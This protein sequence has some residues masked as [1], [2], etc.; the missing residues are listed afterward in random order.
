MVVQWVEMTA[1]QT[2]DQKALKR[3]DPLAGYLV[4]MKAV[5]R[6]EKKVVLWADN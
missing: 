3:A 4:E 2:V 6:V 5:R 1:V